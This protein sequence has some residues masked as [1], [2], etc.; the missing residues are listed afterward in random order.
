[1]G[2]KTMCETRKPEIIVFAG[3]NGSGKTSVTSAARIIKPYVN[4]DE[5][6]S[7]LNCSN[8]EAAEYATAFREKCIE[9]GES[10]S[11]ET[12]LST[13]R[14][15]L[16]LKKAKE[17]GF[18]IRVIYVITCNPDINVARVRVRVLDGGHDV[19]EDKIRSRYKK[20]LD[21]LPQVFKLA[22]V[23]Y[24]YDNTEEP[25]RICKKFHNGKIS[26]FRSKFWSKQ[27]IAHL[28]GLSQTHP[29]NEKNLES[30]E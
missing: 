12:V 17:N 24:V 20:T 22:D 7:S 2:A 19:P 28:I 5:I 14:N 1:M 29:N 30:E 4:A 11:F 8:L 16:L 18:F 15:Y 10:F 25:V 13:D 23:A 3:P 21:L 27:Q 26:I 6:A 9:T